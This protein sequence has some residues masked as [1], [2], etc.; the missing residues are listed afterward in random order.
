MNIFEISANIKKPTKYQST[1]V[2]DFKD[3]CCSSL[4]NEKTLTLEMRKHFR[5]AATEM[6]SS[7]LRLGAIIKI[8]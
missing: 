3:Y 8:I 2:C 6:C 1:L 7:N 5:G 4:E